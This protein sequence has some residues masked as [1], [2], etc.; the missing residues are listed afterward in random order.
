MD[1]HNKEKIML[2]KLPN[3]TAVALLDKEEI[4]DS[5]I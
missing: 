5:T 1:E 4:N 3:K 2:D